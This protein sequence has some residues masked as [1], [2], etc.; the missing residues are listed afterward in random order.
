MSI[1]KGLVTA[2]AAAGLLLT[3]VAAQA[4]P[5]TAGTKYLDRAGV[6][7]TTSSSCTVKFTPIATGLKVNITSI[8]CWIS[9]NETQ[10][11]VEMFATVGIG[12]PQAYLKPS[13][14]GVR[15]GL[16]TYQTNDQ[17][18]LLAFG[19]EQPSVKLSLKDQLKLTELASIDCNFGATI[20]P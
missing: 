7:C 13:M 5:R 17:V 19:G 1:V 10:R 3:A 11:I 4:A 8:S 18:D 12:K 6:T 9:V 16:L 20:V 2:C 14:I 15:T